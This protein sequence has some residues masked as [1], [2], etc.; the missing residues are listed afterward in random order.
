MTSLQGY[1]PFPP[2][3]VCLFASQRGDGPGLP[4]AKRLTGDDSPS[5]AGFHCGPA[6]ATCRPLVDRQLSVAVGGDGM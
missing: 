1:P 5:A 3:F 4:G 2:V 6:A